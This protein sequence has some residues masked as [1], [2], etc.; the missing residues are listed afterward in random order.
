MM[1]STYTSCTQ[2]SLSGTFLALDAAHPASDFGGNYKVM[3]YKEK[4]KN[5]MYVQI[6]KK[7]NDKNSIR[8]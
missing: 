1:C 6:A 5:K 3:Y 2:L 7:S 8:G 4:G